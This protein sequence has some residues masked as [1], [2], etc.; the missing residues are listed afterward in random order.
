MELRPCREQ[1]LESVVSLWDRT[2]RDTYHFIPIEATYTLAANREFFLAHV[3]PRCELWLAEETGSLLGF[4]AID[5]SYVDRLYVDPER[6]LCGVGAALLAKAKEL[7]PAGLELHTHQ[8]S[9]GAR[10][11][12]ESQGMVAVRFGISAPPESEPDVEYW[13]RPVGTVP[14]SSVG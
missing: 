7:S 11:F 9:T 13:W 2:K 4:L 6:Q 3:A 5:G 8:K 12:Y 1:D 10:R 14:K